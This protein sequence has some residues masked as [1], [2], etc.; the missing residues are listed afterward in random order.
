MCSSRPLCKVNQANWVSLHL[1]RLSILKGF[2]AVSKD[3][4]AE[5]GSGD[6]LSRKIYASYQQFRALII[7]WN[8]IAEGAYQNSRRLS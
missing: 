6:A 1:A 4:V 7:D 5:A 8:G 2:L 3:V